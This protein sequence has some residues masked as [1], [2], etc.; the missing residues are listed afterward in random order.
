VPKLAPEPTPAAAKLAAELAADDAPVCNGERLLPGYRC[1][2]H[3]TDAAAARPRP[4]TLAAR[5]DAA[6]V[7]LAWPNFARTTDGRLRQITGRSGGHVYLESDG[8]FRADALE[9]VAEADA[10]AELAADRA[11]DRGRP[12]WPPAAPSWTPPRTAPGPRPSWRWT[13]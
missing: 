9:A 11:D 2:T 12:G 7:P 10:L 13:D 3:R 6:A 1:P 4:G 8:L 5:T